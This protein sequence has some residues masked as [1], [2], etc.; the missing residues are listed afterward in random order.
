WW[1]G[2]AG[3]FALSSAASL[4]TGTRGDGK[5]ARVFQGRWQRGDTHGLE[6]TGRG[7]AG[8]HHQPSAAAMTPYAPARGRGAPSSRGSCTKNILAGLDVSASL[9]D[10]E[11]RAGSGRRS[12]TWRL[13]VLSGSGKMTAAA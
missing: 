6:R 9:M 4:E 3:R 1:K 7:D 8:T 11:D 13:K 12:T 5:T 10:P 2:C